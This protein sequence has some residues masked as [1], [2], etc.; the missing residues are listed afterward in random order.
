MPDAS[1][2]P[3]TTD[4]RRYSLLVQA[5]SL[6][7]GGTRRATGSKPHNGKEVKVRPVALPLNEIRWQYLKNSD[8]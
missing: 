6:A 7:S 2:G 8:T 5:S 4:A 1:R 3:P